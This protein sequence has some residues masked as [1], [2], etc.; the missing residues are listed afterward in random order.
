V[1]LVATRREPEGFRLHRWDVRRRHLEDVSEQLARI[2]SCPAGF[3]DR[4]GHCL[5]SRPSAFCGRRRRRLS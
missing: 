3:G 4:E 5:A 2:T 1:T